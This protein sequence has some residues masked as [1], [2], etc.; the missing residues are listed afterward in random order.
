MAHVDHDL[1]KNVT[2]ADCTA[3]DLQKKQQTAPKQ[4]AKSADYSG[5]A[6]DPEKDPE[7]FGRWMAFMYQAKP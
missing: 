3:D 5:P 7:R 4:P 1:D 2:A 6:P